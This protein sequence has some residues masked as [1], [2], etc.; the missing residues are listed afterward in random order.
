MKSVCSIC[1]YNPV[2]LKIIVFFI[3]FQIIFLVFLYCFNI[4][5]LKIKL[6]NKKPNK[7]NNSF[8]YYREKEEEEEDPF[9]V[10]K[11]SRYMILFST[12]TRG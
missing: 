10:L 2:L 9:V 1:F 11:R 7:N 12:K 5:I 6:K 8:A 4:V 3:L